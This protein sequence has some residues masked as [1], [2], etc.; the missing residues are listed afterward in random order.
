VCPRATT[1][2]IRIVR[3]RSRLLG[4]QKELLMNDSIHRVGLAVASLAVVVTVGGYFVVDGY[5]SAQA[6]AAASPPPAVVY[7]RSAPSAPV[8]QL[9][10][11]APTAPAQVIHVTVPGTGGETDG[12]GD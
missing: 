12:G 9:T 5:R 1:E 6:A 11:T 8:V 2:C 7:V 4:P 10:R 3:V